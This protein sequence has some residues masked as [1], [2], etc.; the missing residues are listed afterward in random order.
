QRFQQCFFE[1]C[2]DKEIEAFVRG[3]VG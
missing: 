1:N 2:Q 3:I